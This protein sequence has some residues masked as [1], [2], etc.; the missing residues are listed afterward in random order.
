MCQTYNL[1]NKQIKEIQIPEAEIYEWTFFDD[2][3]IWSDQ[4]RGFKIFNVSLDSEIYLYSLETGEEKRITSHS[5]TKLT[6]RINGNTV[7][8]QNFG[9][10]LNQLIGNIF[11]NSFSFRLEYERLN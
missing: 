4:R 11:P 8:W 3:I 10:M 7:V 6:P 1:S 2:E 5:G 9:G